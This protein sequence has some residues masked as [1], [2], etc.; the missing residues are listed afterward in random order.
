M[1]S[2]KEKI[3]GPQQIFSSARGLDITITGVTKIWA[4]SELTRPLL[5]APNLL[6]RIAV[7]GI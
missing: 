1:I 6:L 2:V 5:P 7:R 3:V 4:R